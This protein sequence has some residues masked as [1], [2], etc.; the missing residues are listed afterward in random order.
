MTLFMA[1]NESDLL[2][3]CRRGDEQAWNALFKNFYAPATRFIWQ[4]GYDLS[5]EEVE[6]ICQETFLKVIRSIN[7][8]RGECQFQTW[9][10]RLASNTARDFCQHKFAA[11]RGAGQKP[12][13]IDIDNSEDGPPIN[14]P[15]SDLSPDLAL[16]RSEN[17]AL[18]GH[19][20]EQL[21]PACREI[22]D[23]RYFADLSYDEIA[24][25]LSLNP[26]TVSSRLSKCLD[27]LENLLKKLIYHESSRPF[28]V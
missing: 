22:I 7:S 25:S 11:K 19:A 26:K 27:R 6:E 17:I 5:A 15:S 24:T 18:V 14:P 23:L 3:G 13:S 8:F 12:V 10:F 4:L 1:G 21:Q 28:S 20:L 2:E 16:L 9:L